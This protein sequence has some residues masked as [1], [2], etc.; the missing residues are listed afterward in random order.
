MNDLAFVRQTIDLL[1]NRDITTW[2]FGGW[3]GRPVCAA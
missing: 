1:H 3:A 2:L